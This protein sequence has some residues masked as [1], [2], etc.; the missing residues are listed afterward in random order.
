MV[1]WVALVGY[2]LLS[3]SF[4]AYDWS[5]EKALNAFRWVMTPNVWQQL[6]TVGLLLA[7]CQFTVLFT[8]PL[9]SLSLSASPSG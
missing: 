1:G 3:V 6:S 2:S 5:Q 9:V 8:Q 4:W 7:F